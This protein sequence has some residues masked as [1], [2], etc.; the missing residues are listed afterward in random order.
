MKAFTSSKSVPLSFWRSAF[1]ASSLTP[2][3]RSHRKFSVYTQKKS[4]LEIQNLKQE[5][6]KIAMITAYDY[7]SAKHACH[8]D[9]DIILI[10]D[11]VGMVCLGYDSTQPVTMQDMLH[12]CKAV[13]RGAPSKFL[14][15]DMPFGSYESSLVDAFQNAATLVKEGNVDAVKIEGG[16]NRADTVQKL[17]DGGIAVMGHI[18]LTPQAISVLGGFRAQGKTAAKAR[19]LV[20]DALAL[21][22]AGAFAIV[23]ECV[24]ANVA[25]IITNT[26]QIPTIGIGAGSLTSGQV[27]VYHDVLGMMHHPHHEMH[28]PK[29]CK[30]YAQLGIDVHEALSTFR[31]DVLNGSFPSDEFSPF[32]MSEEEIKKFNS[33]LP[34]NLSDTAGSKLT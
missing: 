33:T 21:Q 28:V 17:V 16:A 10:G 29:F 30:K 26:L 12:H 18:G 1:T 25:E 31:S 5:G 4:I 9:F 6:K 34:K 32:K 22:E 3:Q 13:R 14:V 2:C 27:L 19:Q 8:A 23:I 7:P 11:S 24:P 15:G 20:D